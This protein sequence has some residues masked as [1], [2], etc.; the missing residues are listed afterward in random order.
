MSPFELARSIGNNLSGA[1][2]RVKDQNTI[3]SILSEISQS[4]D[5]QVMNDAIGKILSNVSPERQA[6]AIQYIQNSMQR[7]AGQQQAQRQQEAALKGGYDPNAPAFIQKAQFEGK[8][9]QTD[10]DRIIGQQGQPGMAEQ[11]QVANQGLE[12]LNDSQLTQLVGVKGFSEQAKQ[13]LRNRQQEAKAAKSAYEP[14]AEKLEAKRVADLSNQIEKEYISSK[15]EETRLDR[16]MNLSE[17]DELSTP[18]MVKSLEYFGLPIGVL[19]NP[20]TEEY[21]K[22]ET[23]FIRDAR[24]VFPGGRITNYEIQSY[25]KTIPSL[26]NSKEGR[27]AV[28]RNR[29]LFNDAKKVRY[30]EYK[31]IVAENKGKRPQNL[32]IM[33]EE[34]TAD[35]IAEIEDEFKNGIE[36]EIEKFQ[37]PI[38]MID[39]NGQEVLIPPSQIERAVKAGARFQ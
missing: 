27:K 38:R 35:K 37:T 14:E 33:I 24:D 36:K 25:L 12:S 3:D 11:S 19:S 30:D 20:D 13:I 5:P 34:R 7:I 1:F 23:D 32:G 2:E 29:K 4:G 22:L 10:L 21:R 8:Q 39:P 26:L 28:I 17:K 6:P 31:K 15:Q 9:R 16:M 18:L